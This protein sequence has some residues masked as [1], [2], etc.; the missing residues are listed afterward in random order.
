[1]KTLKSLIIYLVCGF[2]ACGVGWAHSSSSA[3]AASFAASH[4]SHMCKYHGVCHLFC[5]SCP[6]NVVRIGVGG[7]YGQYEGGEASGLN[8]AGGYINFYA[9]GASPKERV[10]IALDAHFGA[11]K[12]NMGNF[13]VSADRADTLGIF[14]EVRPMLGLNLLTQNFPLYLNIAYTFNLTNSDS[15]KNNTNG[16][17]NYLHQVGVELEGIIKSS[18]KLRYEYSV[19]YNYVFSGFY[20]SRL[21]GAQTDLGGYNYG[22]RASLGFAYNLSE[23]VHYYMKLKAKY[24][25]LAQ[26]G[27]Y[28]HTQ[29]YIGMLELGIGF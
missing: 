15:G 13:P 16:F 17:V 10:Q 23:S 8:L 1:M 22:V 18:E 27:I 9:R 4:Y 28:P 7:M 25:N 3:I 6:D 19:G 5:E 20:R 21:D 29:Q 12:G 24:Y 26:S 2:G 14:T 11:N